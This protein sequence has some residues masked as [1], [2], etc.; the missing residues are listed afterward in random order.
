LRSSLASIRAGDEFRGPVKAHLVTPSAGLGGQGP[1]PDGT[2]LTGLTGRTMPIDVLLL[3]DMLNSSTPLDLNQPGVLS[4]N[5][6]SLVSQV[7]SADLLPQCRGWNVYIVGAGV[8]ATGSVSDLEYEQL[9]AFWTD[10]FAPCGGQVVLYQNQLTQFPVKALIH[11]RFKSK[12]NPIT[13][14]QQ[15]IVSLPGDVLFASGS[16]NLEP[17]ADPVLAQLLPVVLNQYPNGSIQINGY[18]DN[19]PINIPGRNGELSTERG[20]AVAAWLNQHGVTATR[21]HI[22]G[23]GSADPVASNSTPAGQ[24]QNRRVVV[25]VAT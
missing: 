21:M 5:P 18:T 9:Q 2:S 24:A 6:E 8:P 11:V 17:A 7:R 23:L 20:Q 13:N 10:F 16:A 3:S 15:A 14:Q 19:V 25:A 4:Q 22:L 1:W 12:V